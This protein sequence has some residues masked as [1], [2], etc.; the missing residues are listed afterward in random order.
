[1]LDLATIL[2]CI[3]V[4]F[5]RILDVSLGTI[6]VILIG[7]EKSKTAFFVAFIEIL[8]WFI[9]ARSVLNSDVDVI[10]GVFYSLGYAT[11]TYIGIK[12]TNRFIKGTLS[13][14]IITSKKNDMLIDQLRLGGYAVSV[15]DI[16]GINAE[17]KYLL[18]IEIN[19]QKLEQVQK[20]I[21]KYD[22]SAFVV[23]DETKFVQNGY[24]K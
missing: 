3:Q 15:S 16:R 19:K 1:M 14:Q 17:E 13:I 5:A 8:I 20:I 7:K 2:L 12:I 18:F 11:G 22:K 23:V 10:V 6:R 4:F 21:R 9:V 24:I